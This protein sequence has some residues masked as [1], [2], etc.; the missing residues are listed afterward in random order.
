MDILVMKFTVM[1]KFVLKIWESKVIVST[2]NSKT[3]IPNY[4]NSI[5]PCPSHL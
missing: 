3:H 5:S 2:M 1:I 4:N